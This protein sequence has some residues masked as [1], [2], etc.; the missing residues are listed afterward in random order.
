[1]TANEKDF[2]LVW[3]DTRLG[4]FGG[5][6]VQI[7]F[8]RLQ[9]IDPPS[10]FLS[11]PS[12]TAGRIVD[13]QGFGFQPRSN[14]LLYVSGVAVS[15]LLTDEKGQFTTSIYMPLTGE[16]PTSI[17]AFDESGNAATA[18]FYT[19]FGF[20]S[21]Q[22]AVEAIN[23]QSGGASATPEASPSAGTPVASPVASPT[24]SPAAGS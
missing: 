14:V 6:N 23:Q 17:S 8:A 21:L 16:G 12:G 10:L 19:E 13:I 1:M 2:Y 20:D 3:G 22:R 5:F 7:A 15:S 24:A 9:P 11:P 4:E 18:S